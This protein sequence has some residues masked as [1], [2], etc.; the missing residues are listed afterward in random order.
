MGSPAA[1][2]ADS[3]PWHFEAGNLSQRPTAPQP[4]APLGSL[5][6]WPPAPGYAWPPGPGYVWP[7]A[8]PAAPVSFTPP[9]VLPAP[10]AAP[11]PP[12]PSFWPPPGLPPQPVV[13]SAEAAAPGAEAAL[14]LPGQGAPSV[15][16][17]PPLAVMDFTPPGLLHPP[18][19]AR[20][21]LAPEG[22]AAPSLYAVGVFIGLPAFA[23]LMTIEVALLAGAQ[24]GPSAGPITESVSTVSAVG[25]IAAA[26]AQARQRRADGWQDYSGP[27]PFLATAAVLSLSTAVML[28]LFWL[29]ESVSAL[30]FSSVTALLV[31]AFVSLGCYAGL[32]YLLAVREGALTWRDVARPSH[33]APDP[34]D[35]PEPPAVR[36]WGGLPVP[37]PSRLPGDIGWATALV[38]P[39]L[40]A[41]AV[42][43][44]ALV[45]ILGL[46]DVDVNQP[47]QA[48]DAPDERWLFFLV[49][50]VLVP[51]GEEIFFRGLVT[52]AWARSLGRGDAILR[53]GLFFAFIHVFNVQPGSG[54]VVVRFAILAM[55]ARLPVSLAL[56]WLYIKRRS[57]YAS[58]V[59]HGAYNGAILLASWWVTH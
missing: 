35:A 57:I 59:L 47:V 48:V 5:P 32:V 15:R 51:I 14:T 36:Y 13:A 21:V 7:P 50:A 43:A 29:L 56:S 16:V 18:S 12:R 55:A 24:L 23:L 6:Q 46:N 33:L 37:R 44:V 40:I 45:L 8:A 25:L 49:I 9:A 41:T 22:R 42:L 39:C 10:P 19:P 27:S 2:D 17:Y 52:N 53:A 4:P 3:S 28:P 34:T 20:S 38:I 31:W 58:M 54:D 30:S 1:E 11:S 26:L